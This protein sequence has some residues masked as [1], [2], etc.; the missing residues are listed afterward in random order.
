MITKAV[1]KEISITEIALAL[2]VTAHFKAQFIKLFED[3]AG[4]TSIKEIEHLVA[5]G[6]FTEAMITAETAALGMGTAWSKVFSAAAE[7]VSE[8]L[9]LRLQINVSF[10]QVNVRAVAAMQAAQLRLITEIT[11]AQRMAIRQIIAD[12]ITQGL[13]PRVIAIQ[14]RNT[15]GLTSRQA[16]AVANYRR[17]LET[18]NRDALRRALRDQRFD[19]T[20]E[21]SLSGGRMLEQS[22]IDRMVE[23]YAQ[24]MLAYRAEVIA[25]TE[26][27]DAVGEGMEEMFRQAVDRGQLKLDDLVRTWI[28]RLDG[29]ERGSHHD[30]HR[31]QRGLFER[32][33]TGIGNLLSKPRDPAAPAEDRVECRCSLTYRI[34]SL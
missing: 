16:Q 14:I 2:G 12:G 31:Q 10:D 28:T 20:V 18:N 25:R 32:F 19:P 27:M 1:K 23:R 4:T 30:M 26:A 11:N 8:F 21:R 15:I 7:K 5:T 33:R 9:S 22:Q 34:R 6:Q 3:L 29:R 13:N 17:L 24:R